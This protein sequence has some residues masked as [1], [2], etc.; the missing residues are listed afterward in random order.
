MQRV[1]G[2]APASFKPQVL[3]TEKRLNILFDQLNEGEILR[4][5]T[6]QELRS[7]AENIRGKNFDAGK[8]NVASLMQSGSESNGTAWLV[9]TSAVL[10]AGWLETNDR[11]QV[12]L[13]RLLAMGAAS[14]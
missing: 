4:Q 12:G 7:I 11:R 6:V 1:K 10:A 14:A 3:D 2:I 5:D 13:K 8:S 9:S